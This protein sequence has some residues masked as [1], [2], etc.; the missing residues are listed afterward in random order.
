MGFFA[1]RERVLAHR[2]YLLREKAGR[3][4]TRLA[5]LLFIFD[6][7]GKDVCIHEYQSRRGASE[8]A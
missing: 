1:S 2:F 3:L 5:F 4:N 8:T 6:L 7:R